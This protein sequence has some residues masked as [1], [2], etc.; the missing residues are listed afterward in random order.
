MSI[1]AGCGNMECGSAFATGVIGGI[2]YQGGPLGGHISV[3]SRYAS[4][5]STGLVSGEYWDCGLGRDY[6]IV[7]LHAIAHYYFIHV[8]QSL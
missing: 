8:N 1:T 4:F 7:Q 6:D 3:G 5:L 2:V